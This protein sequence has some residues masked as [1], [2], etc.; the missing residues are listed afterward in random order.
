MHRTM[1]QKILSGRSSALVYAIYRAE[2]LIDLCLDS[3]R[4]SHLLGGGHTGTARAGVSGQHS[5]KQFCP[6]D[7][8]AIFLAEL[9]LRVVFRFGPSE[10]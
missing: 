5:V 2:N 4:F 10:Q 9:G 1:H 6:G 7:V 8:I 3:Q